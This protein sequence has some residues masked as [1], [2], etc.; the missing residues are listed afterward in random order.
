MGIKWK[1][2]L[3]FFLYFFIF[4]ENGVFS[5][6]DPYIKW[7][8]IH[9]PNFSIN[10][11][12]GGEGF[13]KRVANIAEDVHQDLTKLFDFS[14]TERTEILIVNDIDSANGI[15]NV[16][17]YNQITIYAFPPDVEDSLS[18][19]DDWLRQL[20]V[21]EY[22]HILHIDNFGGIPYYLNKILG[23][24]I[25]P[26]ALLPSWWTEG[27]ATLI[28]TVK[29][30]GGR[31]G[32]SIFEMYL[33][34]SYYHKKFFNLNE[35]TDV[36]L[37]LPR[38]TSSYVY[39][40]T[41]F[42][43]LYEK[44]GIERFSKF[45]TEYGKKLLPFGI[46]IISKNIFGKNFIELYEDFKEYYFKKCDEIKQ[47]IENEGIENGEAL[48]RNGE[49]KG[50]PV[51]G[52]DPRTLYFL[53]SNGKEL[54]YIAEFN[55]V[56]RKE[57]KIKKCYGGCDYLWF[58][59]EN[60]ELLYS[61]YDFYK[62]YYVYKDLYSLD[63]KTLKEKR[64]TE[65]M[66]VRWGSKLK[67]G[68]IVFVNSHYE[69]TFLN[70]YDVQKKKVQQ[71]IEGDFDFIISSPKVSPDGK[72]IAYV[73]FKENRWDIYIME[74]EKGEIKRITDN[75]NIE[76]DPS[77]SPD[78]KNILFSSD[79]GGIYNIYIY[80]LENENIFKITNVLGGCFH[81]SMSPDGK[82]VAFLSYSSRGYDLHIVELDERLNLKKDKKKEK[83]KKIQKYEP[84]KISYLSEN[85]NPLETLRP[86]GWKPTYYI[87]T[88]GFSYI[89]ADIEGS[90]VVKYH[91]YLISTGYEFDE[92]RPFILTN[93][94]NNQYFPTLK[95]NAGY[96][97]YNKYAF[98]MDNWLKIRG[99]AYS[100]TF[101]LEIPFPSYKR[102]FYLTTS[103]HFEW[104]RKIESFKE[105]HDPAEQAPF[106]PEFG[107]N[108]LLSFS[109]GYNGLESYTY[110]ISPEYGMSGEITFSTSNSFLG[111]RWS[112]YNIFY[113][114]QGF[115]ENP[116]I[117]THAFSLKTAGG[118]SLGDLKGK[119][120]FALGGM[121]S[122][123][124]IL[125][126]I[127]NTPVGGNFL[128]GYPSQAFLGDRYM[129]Y[130]AEYRFPLLRPFFGPD[131][132][133]LYLKNIHSSIFVDA[134]NSFYKTWSPFYLYWAVGF[135]IKIDTT[136][137]YN[138]PYTIKIGYAHGFK[139]PGGDFLY[140]LLG[141]L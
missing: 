136:F 79:K 78:S 89:G 44:Y 59:R 105:K 121:P 62:T 114:L 99:E 81:P 100:G 61:K 126:I 69:K 91:N 2:N 33:R 127:N 116:F 34:S 135:E 70:L 63:L 138:I 19:F 28:E 53:N 51:F 113:N 23:K 123:D 7:K 95:F 49:I 13:A 31:V 118:I 11:Y 27:L 56:E 20:I 120:I 132:L 104:S 10:Y 122:R 97:P 76:R 141:V 41:F 47:K 80:N 115:I 108:A 26:N 87:D 57:K 134:G 107:R 110:S 48:T 71:L 24:T 82:K 119:H 42:K 9:T 66:R 117:D 128:R 93:W 65:G 46:N 15:A 106:I 112:N 30:S 18:S 25:L 14:P 3:L 73:S 6:S 92:T 36:P 16:Y 96:F 68:N 21:H 111:G 67:N 77:W 37:I 64:I 8:T 124:F 101:S 12:Q 54:P 125:D 60:E 38:G 129:L 85:Y 133:P 50:Y 29:T 40:G 52:K 109:I 75:F 58:D 4:F 103:Y 130:S 35:L 55:I 74:F 102:S 1:Y 72:K 22:T 39:G 17:P 86:R 139:S 98:L 5:G 83:R 131:T 94:T 84:L 43:F 45:I 88:S 140:L 137:F 32:N 90:D